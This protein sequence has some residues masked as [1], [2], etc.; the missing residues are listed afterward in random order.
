MD[1]DKLYSDLIGY[2]SSVETR[3]L[4]PHLANLMEEPNEYELDVKSYCVLCHAAF[5]EFAENI[6][7][8]TM[9]FAIDSFVNGLK[10]SLPLIQLLHFKG[11]STSLEEIDS[12]HYE[13]IRLQLQDI[14][15]DFSKEI[16]IQNHGVS[17]KYLRQLLIPVGIAIPQNAIWLNSLDMLAQA[18]RAYAHKYSKGKVQKNL[19]PEDAKNIVFDVLLLMEKIK[20]NVK[21]LWFFRYTI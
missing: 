15:K 11:K 6:A 5:E 14:K 19:A 20:D 13:Y 16:T 9:L 18:R 8:E 7:L 17:L 21:S 3:Y 12:T 1:S 4:V 10:I 2:I